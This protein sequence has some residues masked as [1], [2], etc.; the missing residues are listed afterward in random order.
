MNLSQLRYLVAVADERHFGRAAER[1]FVSQ[2]TLSTQLKKLEDELGAT[3]FE[4]TNKRVEITAVGTAVVERARRILEEITAIGE[5][6]KGGQSPLSGPLVVGII[7]TLCPYILPWLLPPLRA[8][9]SELDFQVIE[10]LTDNITIMLEQHQLDCMLIAVPGNQPNTVEIP[11]FDEP[12]WV[13]CP[14]RHPLARA[15]AISLRDL[16]KETILYVAEGH[17]LRE[18]TMDI[19]KAGVRS[20]MNRS[21]AFKGAG[22]ETLRRLVAAGLGF[23][24]LPV[25]AMTAGASDSEVIC[26]PYAGY[27][28]RQIGLVYRETYPRPDDMRLLAE[29]VS[30]AL[31]ASVMP[32]L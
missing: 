29:T 3:F 13:A 11:L 1:C 9:F 14:A 25:L 22:L 26:R 15:E 2:P 18:Q 10:D 24:L 30:G 16:S 28:S 4:R 23:T 7:P 27:A 6:T 8:N 31:P 5:L 19:C 17:C 20:D 12:F 32:V 21:D